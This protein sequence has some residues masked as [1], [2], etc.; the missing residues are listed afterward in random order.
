MDWKKNKCGSPND[1]KIK[2][3]INRYANEKKMI[4]HTLR[5]GEQF[6]SLIIEEMIEGIWL[7]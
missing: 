5:H 2:A 3:S 6:Y 1:N 7:R 4:G